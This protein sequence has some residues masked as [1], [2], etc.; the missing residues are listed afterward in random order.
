MKEK[1]R[2]RNAFEAYYVLRRVDAVA[3]EVKYSRLAVTKWKKAFEWDKRCRERTAMIDKQVEVEM[4]PEWTAVKTSLIRTLMN[5]VRHAERLGIKI[6]NSNDLVACSKELRALM[7][8]GDD[9]NNNMT[10]NVVYEK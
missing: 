5:Q 1:P 8:E 9:N 10:I 6:K 7:G 4:M 2:H 3:A